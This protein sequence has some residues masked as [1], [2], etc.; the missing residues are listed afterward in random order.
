MELEDIKSE[1]KWDNVRLADLL[2]KGKGKGIEYYQ[3]VT[4][5]YLNCGGRVASVKCLC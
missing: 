5:I 2:D 3:A 1:L 4:S